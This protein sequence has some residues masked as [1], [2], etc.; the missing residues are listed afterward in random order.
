MDL[1]LELNEIKME[2][3]PDHIL[4]GD[5]CARRIT[6]KR[7]KYLKERE[8]QPKRAKAT[9]SPEKSQLRKNLNRK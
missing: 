3:E 1:D 5:L 7:L 4:L 8:T 9:L 2:V 6:R